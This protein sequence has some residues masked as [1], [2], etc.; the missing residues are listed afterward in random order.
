[1]KA[2]EQI[3]FP[4]KQ[5]RAEPTVPCVLLGES[6]WEDEA[7]RRIQP[8]KIVRCFLGLGIVLRWS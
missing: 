3:V 5:F 4:N 1:L 7:L 6:G 2:F 8:L